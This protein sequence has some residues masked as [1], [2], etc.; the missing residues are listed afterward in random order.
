VPG[1]NSGLSPSDP[2]PETGG[3]YDALAVS[4]SRLTVWR[5]ARGAWGKVQQI[6]VP[7]QYGSSG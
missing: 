4:G 1:M 2:T 5:L 3:S 6:T 7:V